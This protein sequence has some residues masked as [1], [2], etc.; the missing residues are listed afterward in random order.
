MDLR[1]R[2]ERDIVLTKGGVDVFQRAKAAIGTGVHVLMAQADIR[3]T[4]LRR[5]CVGGAFGSFLNI[6]NAQEIGLL[7]TVQP[8]LVELYGNTALAGCEDAMLSHVAA[9]RLEQVRD[10]L[11]FINLSQCLNFDDIFLEHLYLQPAQGE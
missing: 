8:E 11:K 2:G 1:S 4:D 5:I 9:Q 6:A 7:P 10:R 3:Y